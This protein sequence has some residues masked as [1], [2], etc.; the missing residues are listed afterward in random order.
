MQEAR[1]VIEGLV[2]ENA[3]V[4]GVTT[5]FGDLA[6]TF[7]DGAQAGQVQVRDRLVEEGAGARPSMHEEQVERPLPARSVGQRHPVVGA[8]RFHLFLLQGRRPG[9]GAEPR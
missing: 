3:V 7:I 1:D 5:G 4:Y 2:A 6:T 9:A 8:D